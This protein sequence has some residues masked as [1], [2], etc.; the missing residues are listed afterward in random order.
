MKEIHK[1]YDVQ[2]LMQ[3]VNTMKIYPIPML[4]NV[5]RDKRGCTVSIGIEATGLQLTVPFDKMLK[6]LEGKNESV[7]SNSLRAVKGK[8]QKRE[9]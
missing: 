2:G 3:N 1:Q 9:R 7:I 8:D 4:V 5:T 6:D